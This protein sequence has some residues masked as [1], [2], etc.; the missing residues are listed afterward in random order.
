MDH[1][2]NWVFAALCDGLRGW[3]T[4]VFVFNSLIPTA[5]AVLSSL[6][7]KYTTP[8][9]DTRKAHPSKELK[10]EVPSDAF[11]GCLKKAFLDV[12]RGAVDQARD[13]IFSSPSKALNEI[14]LSAAIAG[15]T[16]M[17]TFY[18]DETRILKIANTG[19]ARAVLGRRVKHDDG[20]HHF[21]VHVLSSEHTS[22]NPSEQA[23]LKEFHSNIDISVL[24]KY[25]GRDV[26]RAFGL[27]MF[28]WSQEVQERMHKEY[29]CDPPLRDFQGSDVDPTAEAEGRL[30]LTAEPE[31]TTIQTQPDDFLIMGNQ[32]LW[33]SLT[34]EE[35][36]GLVGAWLLKKHQIL[37]APILEPTDND[38]MERELLPVDLRENSDDTIWYKRWK[39]PKR[40]IFVD[41]NAG[42]H[43]VRN[44]LGGANVTFMGGLLK[45]PHP[46]SARARY[47]VSFSRTV[48]FTPCFL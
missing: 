16:A 11:D 12:E 14:Q 7:S 36:V 42:T 24:R 48:M 27:A 34:S 33:K 44:A 31:I 20:A 46:L 29:F 32:G 40:F 9:G 23:R 22:A 4:S 5:A 28:K 38:F 35:A 39:I 18:D 1:G 43:L 25:I 47:V 10:S 41:N 6:I 30:F 26:T 8:V 45:V 21:E 3:E 17:L 19:D 15:T 37:K 13:M 2:P